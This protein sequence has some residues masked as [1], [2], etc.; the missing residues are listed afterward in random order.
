MV[1]PEHWTTLRAA[2]WARRVPY[3]A[4]PGDISYHFQAHALEVVPDDPDLAG[5]I[6]VSQDVQAVR[7]D[8]GGAA[9]SHQFKHGLAGG[10]VAGSLVSP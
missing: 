8:A 1:A 2:P 4:I 3:P 7:R 10:I 9:S 5:Q 6:K